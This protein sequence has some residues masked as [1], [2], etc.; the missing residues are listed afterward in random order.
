M[1]LPEASEG[2][3]RV[4]IERVQ[5][6][7]DG[8]RFA[9]KR[10]VGQRITVTADAFADGHDVVLVE[11]LDRAP[12]AKTWR[13]RP[14]TELGNDA[15]QAE[16]E[17]AAV[18]RH[19]FT[20]RAWVDAFASWHRDL[21]KRIEAGQDVGV[22]LQIG[23][24]LVAAAAQR[25]NEITSDSTSGNDTRRLA[26]FAQV[27]AGGAA[28]V[29]EYQAG[30]AELAELAARYPDYSHA[31]QCDPPF[32]VVVDRQRAGFSTW[33][34][35]FPRSCADEEGRHGT[36]ADCV[37]WLP[38]LA[39][40]GF[41]VVY[42][43]PIHPIGSTFRK[44]K[45]N[46]VTCE[47]GDVGS[48]WAIGSAEGGHKAIHAE[49]GTLDDLKNLIRAA[50]EHG[51]DLALDIAFQCAPE[52][53]YVKEH[54]DWFKHRPDG[55]IQYAENPPKKYQDIYP[56]D[57]ESSD[58]R[59]LW[60]EL[61][62]VVLY[63]ARQGVRIFRVD[64]PHTKPLAFWEFLISEVKA[65]FPETIFLA[66]A[67]TRPKIMYRLAKSGFSQSYT[68][69]TWRNTKAEFVEYLSEL[70]AE[71]V[72]EFFRPNFWP[73]T[74]DILPPHLQ[75]GNRAAFI[76]RLVLAGTLSGN[77]GI[78]GPAYENLDH[79][80]LKPGSEEYLDSEK[81]QLRHWNFDKPGNLTD[82]ITRLNR[83][84][85][86]NPA[87]QSNRSLRFHPT[88]NEQLICYSK[89]CP[90]SGNLLVM[91]VNLD[92]QQPQWGHVELPLAELGI[93]PGR[94][95]HVVDALSDGKFNW[96]GPRNFV[97]LDP[98]ATPAHILLVRQS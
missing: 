25:A 27:L 34:E 22:D 48:P 43:P 74:P 15:W 55:T 24:P 82:A 31:T 26:H 63:W 38:R 93:D 49:L 78:Y 98:A 50:G 79:L 4:A 39:A 84:R 96:Q 8:G 73:N 76:A 1:P 30:S 20:L 12:G 97:K 61:T 85:R 90:A 91:V 88:D 32:A 80:P 45:N 65:E 87:L 56:F 71:P 40:M 21:R 67:F 10:I 28:G 86:E 69:F 94:A 72:C 37:R 68:Y 44:G 29:A 41:D 46:A 66:E 89:H 16:L 36:F 47:P 81:Y 7:I 54:P 75:S 92:F 59:G 60:Q 51:I 11:L 6:S 9:I 2:R 77:Y 53:P 42:L 95:Y 14:M 18:G 17:L 5:P 57:F 62:D 33:Y 83:A 35:L 58:W 13:V 70:T 19:E 52:H 64:N 3:R 23:A